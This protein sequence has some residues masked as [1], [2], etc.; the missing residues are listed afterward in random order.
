MAKEQPYNVNRMGFASL[1][2]DE[3]NVHD[4]GLQ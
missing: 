4:V 1:I 3:G 2:H